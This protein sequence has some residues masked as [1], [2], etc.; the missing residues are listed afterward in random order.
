MEATSISGLEAMSSGL[1]LV[2]T[3]VGGIPELISDDVNGYLC[4]PADPE[5]LA[6]KINTLLSK[7]LRIMG[8]NSRR[9]VEDHFDW[10]KIA[11]KTEA[12]YRL[13]V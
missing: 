10:G 1:P 5:D 8:G 11:Q 3:R 7:D 12:A 2:G 6:Q 9:L 4:S 13:V